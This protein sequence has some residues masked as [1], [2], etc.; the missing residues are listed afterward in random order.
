MNV[1]V[2]QITATPMP[3]DTEEDIDSGWGSAVSM[4]YQYA[5]WI[6]WWLNTFSSQ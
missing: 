4:F 2:F 5:L 1:I 3:T 6:F